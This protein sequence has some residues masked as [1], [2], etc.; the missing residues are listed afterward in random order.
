MNDSQ[1]Y[2]ELLNKFLEIFD[3]NNVVKIMLEEYSSLLEETMKDK[4]LLELVE[5]N[6]I[7]DVLQ[8]VEGLNSSFFN[9]SQKI[10]KMISTINPSKELERE[11]INK[12][13]NKKTDGGADFIDKVNEDMKNKKENKKPKNKMVNNA[14][15]YIEYII[16]KNISDNKGSEKDE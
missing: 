10:L 8:S 6:K 13:K 12:N 11:K 14:L 16:K 1:E 4:K 3:L 5:S 9:N 7:F 15:D 2:E